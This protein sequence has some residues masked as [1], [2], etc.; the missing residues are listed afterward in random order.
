MGITSVFLKIR[1]A[2]RYLLYLR[3]GAVMNVTIHTLLPNSELKD[4]ICVVTGGAKGLGLVIVKRLLSSGAKVVIVGSN[5]SRLDGA[6]KEL[7]SDDVRT[8]HWDLTDL[9]SLEAK[10]NA[11]AHCFGVGGRGFDVWINNAA[12]LSAA[13]TF[14]KDSTE[15][16]DRTFDL[17]VKS[18]LFV[19]K[20]VCDYYKNKGIQGKIITISSMNAKQAYLDAYYLSKSTADKITEALAVEYVKYGII[21]NGIAPGFLPSGINAA[22][23]TENAYNER[24]Y[25]HRYVLL[26]EVAELALFLSSG[27]ANSIVGQTIMIDGGTTLRT[28]E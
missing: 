18:L 21:V 19:S 16:F 17:N 27:R 22:D 13:P 4:R 5:K 11:I 3:K 7:A 10:I 28:V 6:E 24:N 20:A 1:A 9:R 12:Y 25:S 8:Y 23:V 14:Q 15:T 26:E 2:L